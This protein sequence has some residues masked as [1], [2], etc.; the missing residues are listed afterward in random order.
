MRAADRSEIR[1][2]LAE[3]PE[4]VASGVL[5]PA[6][7]EALKSRYAAQ[8]SE[9]PR[10]TGFILSAI[11][12]SLLV[13][14]GI[15]LLVAHNWDFLSRPIRCAIAFTPLVLSQ[16][17][18]IFVLV[19]RNESAPWRE[20][21][22]ILN[23]AAV[24]T[25][26]AL[27]SQIYQIQG[28]FARFI[29]VWMLLA[30]PVVYLLRTSAGLAVYFIGTMVWVLS[31]KTGDSFGVR[32][33]NLWGWPL[34]FL[35]L[36]AF[37]DLLRRNRNGYGTLLAASSLT[38]AAAFALAKTD[39]MGAQSFWRCAFAGF[40]SVFYLVG[41]GYFKDW[42]PTR[43]H[44]FVWIGWIAILSLTI[45][46]SFKDSWRTHQWQRA[47]DFVPRHYPDAL[48]VGIQIAWVL[49]ALLLGAYTFWKE[50]RTRVNL[51]PAALAPV[52]LVAWGIAK[53]T[54]DPL[55]P[56]LLLNL[57]GLALGLYTLIRG[58][59]AGRIYE[60]NLGMFI[61][62]ALAVARFFDSDFEF[63]VRGIAFIAIGLGF[64]VTNLVVFER[65]ARA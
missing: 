53:R 26:I 47:V 59:R 6:A 17:L 27:V 43:A 11:L 3:L 58:V 52:V 41:A 32:P 19:R 62:A 34:I 61:I 60:A 42:R 20:S 16:A 18:A 10:R 1:W 35:G 8:L 44:P 15:I 13:G 49:G 65:R 23:V 28:D 30:I 64:L 31:S 50:F 56:S 55:L 57:F 37:I 4:L 25:A 29:L 22:A 5:T 48:P 12:G 63:V 51:A 54:R 46:L 2:L 14:A 24:G 33:N 40:W 9:E 36:P 45:L 7:A 39:E 21:A 38:L